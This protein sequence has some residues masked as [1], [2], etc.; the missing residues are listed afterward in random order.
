MFGQRC[1]I[2]QAYNAKLTRGKPISN[3]DGKSLLELY[4]KMSDCVVALDQLSIYM[5]LIVPMF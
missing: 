4:Y 2:S 5:T 1:R 3:K